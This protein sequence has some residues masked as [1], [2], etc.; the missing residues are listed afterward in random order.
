MKPMTLPYALFITLILGCDFEDLSGPAPRSTL[1]E[2]RELGQAPVDDALHHRLAAE[3]QLL[4]DPDGIGEVDQIRF[5]LFAGTLADPPAHLGALRTDPALRGKVLRDR[6]LGGVDSRSAAVFDD[7]AE[8]SYTV[9]VSAGPGPDPERDQVVARAV[10]A[11]EA[12]GDGGLTAAKL[13][14]AVA[15]AQ[16]ETGYVPR[17]TDWSAHPAHCRRIAVTSEPAS[18]VAVIDIG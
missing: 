4:V 10:A 17:R 5:A 7:V 8:G 3:R 15:Q 2:Q 1:A 9:C 14:A 13:Q 11:Y 16:A 6:L 12:A 18:R